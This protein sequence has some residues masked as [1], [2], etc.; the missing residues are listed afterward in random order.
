MDPSMPT[1]RDHRLAVAADRLPRPQATAANWVGWSRDGPFQRLL[2]VHD[3]AVAANLLPD[4]AQSAWAAANYDPG[5]QQA[6][7]TQHG[8]RSLWSETENAYAAW[9]RAGCP[10]RSRFGLT[11]MA[12]GQQVWLD[13]P[14]H[15]VTT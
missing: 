10:R 2:R 14:E 12:S 3:D 11:I 1:W 6:Q 9:L 4:D 5:T 8:E 15:I 13:E 7:I